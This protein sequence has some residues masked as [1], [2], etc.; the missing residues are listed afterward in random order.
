[1]PSHNPIN[2]QALDHVVIRTRDLDAM[3]KFYRDVLGCPVERERTDLGLT[4]LRAGNALIDI[5]TV[6]S[7]LGKLGGR[8]PE[9]N[10]RN[11]D[12]FCLQ[13]SPFIE[14]D[15]LLYLE[16]QGVETG[17]FSKRYGAQ[18]FGRSLYIY[19]PEGNVVEL[20]PQIT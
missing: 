11:V 14:E 5:V 17:E 10:G 9:Q 1:M 19:D 20:K 13:L 6:D 7:K 16:S 2:I 18:G 4:Q 3:L 8:P 15:L 12:H